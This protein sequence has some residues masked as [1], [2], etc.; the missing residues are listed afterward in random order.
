MKLAPLIDNLSRHFSRVDQVSDAVLRG[1]KEYKA[2][3]YALMYFDSSKRFT[4]PDFDL[5]NYQQKLLSAD[6]YAHP[7]PLQWNMYLFL[8]GDAEE[9]D[10]LRKA[11]AIERIEQDRVFA[12]KIVVT[13]EELSQAFTETEGVD[14]EFSTADAD[15][16]VG[17]IQRLKDVQLDGV[18]MDQGYLSVVDSYLAGTPITEPTINEEIS[19][20]ENSDK[21]SNISFLESLTMQNYRCFVNRTEHFGMVNLIQGPNGSGKTSLMEAIELCL[22]GASFRNPR[23]VETD[24]TLS[25]SVRGNAVP[26]QYN[27]YDNALYRGRDLRWYGNFYMRGNH[28]CYGFN[29]FN[30]YDTDAASRLVHGDASN[31]ALENSIS[32]LLMGQRANAI[33]DRAEKFLVEFQGRARSLQRNADDL[34]AANLRLNAERQ[35]LTAPAVD[36]GPLRDLLVNELSNFRWKGNAAFDSRESLDL[37][38]NELDNVDLRLETCL[39]SLSWL[40]PATRS[41]LGSQTKEVQV[42]LERL[43]EIR[44][45]AN[46]TESEMAA[47]A[48]NQTNATHS[49]NLVAAL[50]PY[51]A[52]PES[53]FLLGLESRLAATE[54]ELKLYADAWAIVETV[55]VES[56]RSLLQ[57]AVELERQLSTDIATAGAEWRSL[58]EKEKKVREHADKAQRLRSQVRATT[59]ELLDLDP[60]VQEC[61]VCRTRFEKKDL[62]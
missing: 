49:L 31:E 7:G 38:I 16:A 40:A 17:W 41:R 28:L 19:L 62:I 37:L 34:E 9:I 26:E 10:R 18:F 45:T 60:N 2:N 51:L 32:S 12:R 43:S 8:L 30:H 59:A 39:A 25:L 36:S 57:T 15:L 52:N 29:R 27:P 13:P 6:Y 23:S 42:A 53:K 1:T 4:Q 11:G 48:K 50:E 20:Q 3:P 47:L 46:A 14:S 21:P 35:R 54:R 24:S 44:Q 56:F 5:Q 33:H 22:C 61:P 55:D 58:V